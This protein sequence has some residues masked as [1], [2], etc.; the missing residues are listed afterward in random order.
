MKLKKLF[1]ITLVVLMLNA[2]LGVT[3]MAGVDPHAWYLQSNIMQ[4]K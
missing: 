1:V 4:A 2:A 3:A